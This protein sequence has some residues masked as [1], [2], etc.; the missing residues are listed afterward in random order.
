M[1]DKNK[2]FLYKGGESKGMDDVKST[3]KI[4]KKV[5]PPKKAPAKAKAKRGMK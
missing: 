5:M 3:G 1:K 4:P 2:G